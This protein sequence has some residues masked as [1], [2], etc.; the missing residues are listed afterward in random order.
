MYVVLTAI[1]Q[2]IKK[3]KSMKKNKIFKGL[4]LAL[5]VSATMVSTSCKDEPDKYEIADGTPSVYFIRPVSAA[6]RDSIITAASLRQTLCVVGENLRSVT[7]L[8]FNDQAAVLNTSY[9]TDNT[10][11][12]TVPNEIPNTVT[13]KMYL[14]TNSQDTVAYDFKVTIPAPVVSSMSNEWAFPGEEVTIIGDYFLDYKE[15]PITVNF[16]DYTLPRSAISSITKN[17]ITFTMPDGVPE[18]KVSV[19]SIYG[20]TSGAFKYCDDRGMLF[21]FDTP[22]KT[23]VVLGNNG[24]HNRPIVSDET[25]LSGNYMY[26]GGVAMGSDGGWN[27]GDFSF[28][29]WAGNWGNPETYKEK[30]RISD[31]A[32]FTDFENLNLKFEMNIPEGN[33]WSAA[34]I[35]IYFGGVDKVSCTNAGVPDIYGNILAGCNNTFFHEQGTLPRALYMPWKDSDDLLY[36]TSGK[37]VTVTI[38][39]TDFNMD[40]DGSKLSSGYSSVSDFGSFNM[41]VIKGGYNDKSVLP[42]GVDCIPLIKI[43]NIRVVPNK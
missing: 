36:H 32:D 37:W 27:D 10:I 14:I 34:P 7:K 40:Y 29:Y 1:N 19:T 11:I 41:F 38:P 3:Q 5:V 16:G 8:L 13:D 2:V 43:D 15:F 20:K 42:E 39:L 25:S 23:G 17:R 9:M 21:D 31:L 28:E 6:S 35:Q 26:L 18:E 12:V 30:P 22:C 33:A 24:W 4:F